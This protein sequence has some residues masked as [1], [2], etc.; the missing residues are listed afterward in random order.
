MGS[1]PVALWLN[2]GGFSV[3]ADDLLE[4]SPVDRV[5]YLLLIV[6]GLIV[7]LHRPINWS[8]LI[9]GNGWIVLLFVYGAIS[10][11][12]SDYPFVAFKRWIRGI[13]TIVMILIILTEDDPVEAVTTLIR[14]TAYV[15]IPLSIILIKYYPGIGIGYDTWT[16]A[17]YYSGVT[18]S[19][20]ELG[21]LC[22]IFGF[23][24]F[25]NIY[26]NWRDISQNKKKIFLNAIIILLLARLFMLAHSATSTA[27]FIAGVLFLLI[28]KRPGIRKN[29]HN[30]GFYFIITAAVYFLLDWSMD[31]R[32]IIIEILG[33]NATLTDRTH[34]WNILL[35]VGTNPWIGTGYE[36]F[37]LGNRLNSLW[38]SW[39][40]GHVN[41][42]HSG[43]LEIYLNQGFLGLALFLIV[44]I[45]AFRN[46]KK[47][48][49]TNFNYGMF[50]MGMLIMIL[51]YNYTES[52]FRMQSMV[53]FIFYIIA[54]KV[55]KSPQSRI[56]EQF[57][58]T[59][60]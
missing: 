30:I 50:T 24:F 18:T 44:I 25:W 52:G 3:L 32:R 38:S 19:K 53:L 42:A 15:F 46:S 4:G 47:E 48:L 20:N 1:K 7:L 21:R 33:R 37:W 39:A 41:E 40:Y 55:P 2:P 49:I 45:T 57:N 8:R 60:Q 11:I 31:L 51:L 58:P 26:S 9:V 23:Y 28:I 35:N 29:A 14:R 56:P 16:G 6:F 5:I 12:W 43:Y 36:S 22:M 13:G 17:K 27:C 59:L 10:I 34:I 54:I